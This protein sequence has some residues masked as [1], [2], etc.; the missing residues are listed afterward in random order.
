M[1]V[2]CLIGKDARLSVR[3]VV[4][5][6]RRPGRYI[7]FA[8][9]PGQRIVVILCRQRI[10]LQYGYQVAVGIIAVSVDI[11]FRINETNQVDVML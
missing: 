5:R 1:A 10:I 11:L 4:K 6:F 8:D 9:L 3:I 2:S 7:F